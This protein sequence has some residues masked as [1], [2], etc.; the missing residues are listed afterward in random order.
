MTVAH[1]A[2]VEDVER[3]R[4]ALADQGVEQHAD[5]L[6]RTVFRSGQVD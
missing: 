4:A 3:W 2:L 6:A 1:P 5:Q